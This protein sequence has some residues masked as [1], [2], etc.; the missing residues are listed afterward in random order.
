Y[1]LDPFTYNR[2]ALAD[3]SAF[4]AADMNYA[5][6]DPNID[7]RALRREHVR[8]MRTTPDVVVAG[9]SG[10]Q[11]ASAGLL[12][13]RKFFEAF[14]HYVSYEDL[15]A[16]AE[17]LRANDRLPKT[18]V[19]NVRLVAVFNPTHWK[20]WAPEYRSMARLLGL[21]DPGWFNTFAFDKWMNLLS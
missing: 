13:G 19:L 21:E 9:G 16:T 15:L 8:Q 18:L 20:E 14:G 10:W 2:A 5:V 17:L 1:S 6:L 12:P 3:M 11:E 7:L 4:L